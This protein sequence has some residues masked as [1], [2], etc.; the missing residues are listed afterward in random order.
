MDTEADQIINDLAVPYQEIGA[1][2]PKQRRFNRIVNAGLI[3]TL[4]GLGYIII[5]SSSLYKSPELYVVAI[6][7]GVSL[8]IL[9]IFTRKFRKVA[10]NSEENIFIVAYELMSELKQ[11][12]LPIDMSG[13]ASDLESLI[14]YL[15]QN[16]V[17]GF[18]LAKEA[19]SSV[20]DFLKNLRFRLLQAVLKGKTEDVR[21][22]VW[23][24]AKLCQILLNEHPKVSQIEEINN[25]LSKLPKWEEVEK[26]KFNVKMRL[27]I[28]NHST[29]GISFGCALVGIGII[30]LGNFLGHP[31]EGFTAGVGGAIALFVGFLL[32]PRLKKQ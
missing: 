24:L 11:Y 8:L 15:E 32:S 14:T 19:L 17:L 7:I 4:L 9:G 3:T 6:W 1:R 29:V 27:W 23:T 28:G 2:L 26:V 21:L 13:P 16:W 30:A 10:L 12:P 5:F 18:P 25:E 22:S 31:A 20:A